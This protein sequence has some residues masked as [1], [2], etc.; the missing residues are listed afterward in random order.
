MFNRPTRTV[1]L[2][3]KATPTATP[4]KAKV[5]PLRIMSTTKKIQTHFNDTVLVDDQEKQ[6]NGF[7]LEPYLVILSGLDQGKQHRLHQQFNTLGRTNNTD[8]KISDTKIS[9]NHGVLILYPDKIVLEDQ[10]STNGCFVDE[11]KVEQ[12][13]IESTARIRLGNT[14][15]KI[16]YK[17]ANEVEAEL[18]LHQAANTDALTNIANRRAFMA[19]AEEE[20][21]FCIRNNTELAIVMCDVDHFKHTNDTFGHPAGDKVLKD[22]AKILQSEMR[23][24]DMLAR[25]GGEEFIM[26]LRSTDL[27]SIK[28][29]SERVRQKIEQFP[30]V[31]ENIT[32]PTTLSI[33]VVTV[34]GEKTILLETLIKKADKNLYQAKNKGRNRVE[35][36]SE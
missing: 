16:E 32:I 13:S 4:F 20:V 22:L 31:F 21:S 28:L 19:R 10:N 24:E 26:L 27:N 25:F 15:M 12:Q 2:F 8:I 30:F 34:K 11:I 1:S 17:N 5:P 9:R 33:G 29:W 6:A 14:I 36:T 18:N 23:Q 35:I 7:F 3:T